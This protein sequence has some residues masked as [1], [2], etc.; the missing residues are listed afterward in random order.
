M[1]H[2]RTIRL[3]EFNPMAICSTL[4]GMVVVTIDQV[5]TLD[6]GGHIIKKFGSS[7]HGDGQLDR[8]YGIG[9]NSRNEIIIS[10]YFDHTVFSESGEFLRSFGSQRRGIDCLDFPKGICIDRDDNVY[11]ADSDRIN[12]FNPQGLSIQQIYVP[13]PIALCLSNKQLVVTSGNGSIR[14]F[15][16]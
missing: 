12:I 5:L 4:T 6:L 8:P 9:Y 2:I 1:K 14:V 10:D 16:Y 13:K 11:V 15:S 3:D 7:G